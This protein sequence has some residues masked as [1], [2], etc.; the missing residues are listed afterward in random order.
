MR[1]G[2]AWGWERQMLLQLYSDLVA[3]YRPV[4]IPSSQT[5]SMHFQREIYLQKESS[6][7]QSLD[8]FVSSEGFD[9][10]TLA[11]IPA[12]KLQTTIN[13]WCIVWISGMFSVKSLGIVTM[14]VR[15]AHFPVWITKP[16]DTYRCIISILKP[17]LSSLMQIS[18]NVIKKPK[19]ES[20]DVT[21]G[22]NIYLKLRCI[23][24]FACLIFR[25]D[26]VV[27]C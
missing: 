19:D 3:H 6:T 9:R 15:Y 23:K 16:T 22:K 25:W 8:S 13:I 14:V 10:H 17:L 7:M 20:K 18:M 24:V 12:L 21:A 26:G 27:V 11:L 5:Y 2:Q 4:Q 1:K